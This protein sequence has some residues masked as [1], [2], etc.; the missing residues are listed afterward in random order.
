MRIRMKFGDRP[1]L[2]LAANLLLLVGTASM[3]LFA[4][5]LLDGTYYQYTQKI[6]FAS[7]T[8]GAWLRAEA[9]G[10][11]RQLLFPT[12][13]RNRRPEFSF[14]R[15]HSN[16]RSNCRLAIHCSSANWKCPT[17]G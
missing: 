3:L 15:I 9:P 1:L 8:A 5:S 4:W 17:L 16:C 11:H 2:G 13:V 12:P 7:K 6:Q 14:S 10:A